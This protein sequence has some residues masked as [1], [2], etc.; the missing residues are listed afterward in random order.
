MWPLQRPAITARTSYDTC[1][2]STQDKKRREMLQ[3]AAG[4]V[5][6]AGRRF[7][8]AVAKGT[9]HKLRKDAFQLPGITGTQ[10]YTWAYENGMVGRKNGRRLYDQLMAAPEHDTC[11][12][13][14]QGMVRTL[15]HFLPKADFAAL[16]VDPLNLIPACADCNKAKGDKAPQTPETVTLHPYLDNIDD[17]PWL[18]ARVVRESPTWLEYF[19]TP[20]GHWDELLT[21]RTSHHFEVFN[22]AELYSSQAGRNLNSI[23]QQLDD[24]LE[25][26]GPQSVRAYLEGEARTRRAARL[27]GWETAAYQAWAQDDWFCAGGWTDI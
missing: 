11:P 23:R 12:L 8:K 1:V 13:C 15:D 19:I 22:L 25:T 24:L 5:E 4:N 21:H 20:P 9:L 2:D 14:G 17:C 16:C 18:T 26:T 3:K 27:N 6:K 10:A 7:R